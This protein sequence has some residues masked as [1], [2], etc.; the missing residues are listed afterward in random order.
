[1]DVTS[2]LAGAGPL[3][4]VLVAAI[5]FVENGLL[6]PFLPGDSLLFAASLL[7]ERL[8]LPWVVVAA[9]AASAA[10]TG[11][12]LGFRLG[13]RYGRAL[14]K[15]NSRLLRQSR[16]DEANV[17]F[18][19]FGGLS[20]LLGRFVPMVRTFISP[21]I[22][23]STMPHRTFSMW[24]AA[25]ATGWAFGLAFLGSLLGGVPWVAANVE[26]LSLLVVA[27]SLAPLAVT[28]LV[29]SRRRVGESGR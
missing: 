23:I 28:A 9:V 17:F 18:A 10:M 12:E 8:A 13:R 26:L 25:G 15:P 11:A 29:R 5:V 7:A 2:L 3:A 21:V 1:M 19:R 6:F 4:L 22:G 20:V 14:F 24:N 16:L 27:A